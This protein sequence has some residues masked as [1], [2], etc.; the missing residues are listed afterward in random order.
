M[1]C[2]IKRT[3]IP[4]DEWL[5]IKLFT[6][7][8][9]A[10]TLLTEVLPDI[11]S[12]LKENQVL[13]KWF[14]IRYSDP[15]FHLRV[16]FYIK[17]QDHSSILSVIS[18]SIKSYVSD[19]LIWK[20]QADTY[21]RELERY[22]TKTIEHIET[23]FNIDSEAI[24]SLLG[25]L[26]GYEAEQH[27]WLLALKMIDVL[28]D[29]FKFGIENKL[30]LLNTL[31]ENFK[32]EFGFTQKEYKIQLDKKFRNNRQA[33]EETIINQPDSWMALYSAI[34]QHKSQAL[35]PIVKLL[36]KMETQQELEV[37]LKSLLG[38]QIHMMINRLFRSKQR[39]VEMVLYDMLER[40]YSSTVAKSKY[41][42]LNNVSMDKVEE[43]II[44]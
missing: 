23:I 33:I 3:F 27:R 25:K 7:Y 22:G 28:L 37:P 38:S 30:E 26:E 1:N 18:Q 34:I 17:D 32:K 31:S 2:N 13:D 24:V 43:T 12:R 9:T 4:G 36:L 15:H 14:F 16:R 10:D 21:Q 20:V 39:I 6:G 8:K 19:G 42:R 41:K 11:I 5:Y 44:M 40:Y 29:D 35:Q